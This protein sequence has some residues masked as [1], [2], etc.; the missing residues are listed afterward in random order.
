MATPRLYGPLPLTVERVGRHLL[1][2]SPGVYAL[3]KEQDG[4]FVIGEVGRSDH[5][6]RSALTAQVGGRFSQFK[7][8]Y[9]LSAE[10][11]FRTECELYHTVTLDH[12]IHP[13]APAG[14]YLQCSACHPT[15]VAPQ[16]RSS[17]RPESAN[18]NLQDVMPCPEAGHLFD[19]Y[20][21]A[22]AEFHDAK[23]PFSGTANLSDSPNLERDAFARLKT[24]RIQ[25]WSHVT[26]HGCRMPVGS[27]AARLEIERRLRTDMREA[28]REFVAA[29]DQFDQLIGVA[30]DSHGSADGVLAR[31]QAKRLREAAFQRYDAALRRY[32][33]FVVGKAE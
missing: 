29:S 27:S 30:L 18:P 17:H 16:P 11:A 4:L 33:E 3:G 28:R 8:R 31:E 7:F 10:D 20:C 9:A 14:T 19:L 26:E 25:Y 23:L 6:L 1:E 5:D 13:I 2:S 15:F 32:A 12:P 24:A 21:R 22:L